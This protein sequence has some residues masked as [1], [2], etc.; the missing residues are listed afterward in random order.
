MSRR[1]KGFRG[2][3]FSLTKMHKSTQVFAG[4]K[5]GAQAAWAAFDRKNS[6]R[7]AKGQR[8]SGGGMIRF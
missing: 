5:P 7:R 2:L 1:L 3:H 6:A 4:L 8:G